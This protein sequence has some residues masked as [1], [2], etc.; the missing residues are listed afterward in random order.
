M[1][2]CYVC[3]FQ[4]VD[5]AP[6]CVK[7]RARKPAPGEKPKGRS[8]HAMQETARAREAD[9][10][11]QQQLAPAPA[12]HQL[13]ASWREITVDPAEVPLELAKLDRRDY[14]LRDAIRLLIDV[15]KNPQAAGRDEKL[16]M[17][18]N[19]LVDWEQDEVI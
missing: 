4:N 17:A 5:A 14:A 19:L 6:V 11:M 10:M 2:E 18:I 9:R 7:C 8:F 15:T 1:W 12:M 16:A 3:G 13:E